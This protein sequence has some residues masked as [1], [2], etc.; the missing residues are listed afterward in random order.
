M[1]I[2][3]EPGDIVVA[4]VPFRDYV[5]IITQHGYMYSLWMTDIGNYRVQLL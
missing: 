1:K 3:L 2:N 4:M 5:L